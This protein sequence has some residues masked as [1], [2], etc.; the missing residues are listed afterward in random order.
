M[1]TKTQFEEHG[2]NCNVDNII[3]V[4]FGTTGETYLAPVTTGN[5]TGISTAEEN[6]VIEYMDTE[7]GSGVHDSNAQLD[8]IQVG[9]KTPC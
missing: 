5:G 3:N 8:W 1:I 7:S 4:N 6:D 2:N 9:I